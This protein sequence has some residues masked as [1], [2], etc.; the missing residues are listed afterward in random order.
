MTPRCLVAIELGPMDVV[1]TRINPG[2]AGVAVEHSE[3]LPLPP[4]GEGGP[5][6]RGAA[7]RS[8]LKSAGLS[9][10]QALLVLPRAG[11]MV[12]PVEVPESAISS[13]SLPEVVRLRFE[14][15]ASVAA[16]QALVIDFL[17]P[18]E[19]RS[20]VLAGAVRRGELERSV[21]VLKGAGIRPVSCVV[22]GASL[23]TLDA[24]ETRG[25]RMLMTPTPS[26]ADL[27]VV[28][29]GELVHAS[30]VGNVGMTGANSG[31]GVVDSVADAA[32][33]DVERTLMS[34]WFSS[35]AIG[36][37]AAQVLA[38]ESERSQRLAQRLGKRL[39]LEVPVGVPDDGQTHVSL[40][41]GD[42]SGL[43]LAHA[44]ALMT[45]PERAFDFLHPRRAP[46][47]KGQARRIA[48]LAAVLLIGVTGVTSYAA[49][50]DL[51]SIRS[52]VGRLTSRA[53]EKTEAHREHQRE[54]ARVEHL[55]A[56]TGSTTSASDVLHDLHGVIPGP[57][58]ALIDAIRLGRSFEVGFRPRSV[59]GGGGR[60]RAYAGGSWSENA[61][62][63]LTLSATTRDRE[64][65]IEV[66]EAL[67]DSGWYH[68]RTRAADVE[69]RLELELRVLERAQPE[70]E[71][72]TDSVEGEGS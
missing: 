54:T 40:G 42:L 10:K 46:D 36:L 35:G 51:K 1:V 52:E 14:R 43:G 38:Q 33:L 26:G 41:D 68:L 61:S 66:R 72:E 24:G 48:M 45:A 2:K 11:A 25:V 18:R 8:A 47:T 53:K 7:L 32:A 64:A 30:S 9:T 17:P 55:E 56:L 19:G 15:R 69:D 31:D 28:A 70:P 22:R 20:A 57:G 13:P 3:R 49:W 12:R 39:G 4:E 27:A 29:D 21:A 71:A 58:P 6:E 16:E 34:P 59:S 50:R 37:D 23:A 44:A 60:R 63:R 67:L 5:R 65:L 62:D